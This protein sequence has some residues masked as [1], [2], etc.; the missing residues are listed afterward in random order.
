[1][2]PTR[3]I[4]LV[5]ILL[6]I[7]GYLIAA[8]TY[9]VPSGPPYRTEYV[10]NPT[11]R[12]GGDVEVATKYYDLVP[13]WVRIGSEYVILFAVPALLIFL[14]LIADTKP[15]KMLKKPW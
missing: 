15:P 7:V 12:I 14:Y 1:M 5:F 6:G 2:S 13:L 4:V 11:G 8:N 9:D 3:R 10:E